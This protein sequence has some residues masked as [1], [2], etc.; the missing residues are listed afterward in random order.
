[1]S[2]DYAYQRQDQGGRITHMW[3]LKGPLGGVHIWARPEDAEWA[4]KWGKYYCGGV[5]RHSPRPVYDWEKQDEPHHAD[6]F[7]LGGPC[8]HDG[9]SLYFSERIAP[10]LERKEP[11]S[12]GTVAFLHS[13]LHDFYVSNFGEATP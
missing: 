9:T 10:M 13:V 1:M 3:T 4:E 6:C 7:L 2:M 5:E 11:F 12:A 8:W